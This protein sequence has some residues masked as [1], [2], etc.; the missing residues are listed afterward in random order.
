MYPTM[1]P[2]NPIHLFTPHHTG[3]FLLQAVPG[4]AIRTGPYVV[5]QQ[6]GVGVQCL[7]DVADVASLVIY[8]V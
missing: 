5:Q 3:R 4:L 2:R 8:A 6:A 1:G 7:F